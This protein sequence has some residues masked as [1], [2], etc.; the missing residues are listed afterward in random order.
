VRMGG[1]G[2]V[3]DETGGKDHER[4]G[5]GGGVSKR[6]AKQRMHDE[7]EMK[8]TNCRVLLSIVILQRWVP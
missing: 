1:D 4:G 7:S 8:R 5:G 2:A 3:W 6:G